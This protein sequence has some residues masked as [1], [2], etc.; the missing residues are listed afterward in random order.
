MEHKAALR[1]IPPLALPSLGLS[2]AMSPQ[3]SQE[4]PTVE[5][6]SLA[7]TGQL[8]L[9]AADRELPPLL[10]L[11][12]GG[13]SGVV[14]GE[15]GEG[16]RRLQVGLLYGGFVLEI[17]PPP[18]ATPMEHRCLTKISNFNCQTP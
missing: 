5:H 3:R 14:S 11:L 17:P 12:A 16:M 10:F 1:S 4:V 9:A 15:G 13:S 18:V 7:A 8:P 6:A 2:G